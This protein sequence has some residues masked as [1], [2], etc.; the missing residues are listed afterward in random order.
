MDFSLLLLKGWGNE[1]EQYFVELFYDL[2][3]GN[4]NGGTVPFYAMEKGKEILFSLLHTNIVRS[5]SCYLN[6]V[7]LE[8]LIYANTVL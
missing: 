6:G 5:G 7:T 8:G 2:Y 4:G 1:R 3:M